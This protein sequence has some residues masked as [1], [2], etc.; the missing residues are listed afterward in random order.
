MLLIL[1]HQVQRPCTGW[2]LQVNS[3]HYP[4]FFGPAQAC[5][6]DQVIMMH[7]NQVQQSPWAGP[8][9]AMPSSS[10]LHRA[11]LD[12]T[13]LHSGSS[14]QLRS[15]LEILLR[16][17]RVVWPPLPTR[18]ASASQ[19]SKV[20]GTPGRPEY[21][22]AT[23][24]L[25]TSVSK[26]V[27]IS[28]GNKLGIIDILVRTLRELIDKYYGITEHRMDNIKSVIETTRKWDGHN[29]QL[30]RDLGRTRI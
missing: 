15:G 8:Q 14:V 18:N 23:E 1:L 19:Y 10:A 21:H 26:E 22:L 30:G 5:L 28:Y 27:H 4:G 11:G 13:S 25:D 20:A 7:L 12:T 9:R 6:D 24:R 3:A 2:A 17:C 29:E 16:I